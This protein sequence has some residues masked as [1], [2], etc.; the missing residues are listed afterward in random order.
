MVNEQVASSLPLPP[1]RPG[2]I[3]K[4]LGWNFTAALI[5]AMLL[6]LLHIGRKDLLYAVA[7]VYF[8]P[9]PIVNGILLLINA[10]RTNGTRSELIGYLLATI[11]MALIGVGIFLIGLQVHGLHVQ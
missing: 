8:I 10:L 6:V 5:S 11:L 9:F 2:S 4:I 7:L 1:Q 3:L